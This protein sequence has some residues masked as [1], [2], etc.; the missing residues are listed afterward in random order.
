ME[1]NDI[2]IYIYT[3]VYVGS[4][5]TYFFSFVTFSFEVNLVINNIY[6]KSIVVVIRFKT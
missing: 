3:T 1:L 5:L 4:Q 6:I 2:Y